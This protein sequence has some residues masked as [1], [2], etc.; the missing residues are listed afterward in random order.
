M[1]SLSYVYNDPFLK[2]LVSQ[3]NEDDALASLATMGSFTDVQLETL[4]P[5]RSYI[6]CCIDSVKAPDDIFATKKK[7]FEKELTDAIALARIVPAVEGT[8]SL[9]FTMAIER[10]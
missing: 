4:V 7:Y 6:L 2:G 3:R 8:P 9:I 5:L 10:N 1:A